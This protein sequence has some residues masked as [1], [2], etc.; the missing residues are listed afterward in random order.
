MPDDAQYLNLDDPA[1]YR[2]CAQGVFDACWL[3]MLSGD[4]VI[5]RRTASRQRVTTLVGQVADQAALLGVLEQLSSLGLPIL[6]VEC[7][8]END[9]VTR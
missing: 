7:L 2:I 9:K 6:S 1:H 5:R 3:D 4:W 8:S